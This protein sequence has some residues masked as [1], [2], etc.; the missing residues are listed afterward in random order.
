MRIIFSQHINFSFSLMKT[1]WRSFITYNINF[2]PV[3][4]NSVGSEFCLINLVDWC[5]ISTRLTTNMLFK[6][7]KFITQKFHF[8][9]DQITYFFNEIGWSAIMR[10]SFWHTWYFS[11]FFTTVASDATIFWGSHSVFGFSEY[12]FHCVL[13]IAVFFYCYFF[14][15][16]LINR[17]WIEKPIFLINHRF[18]I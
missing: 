16:N 12:V 9:I 14:L 15:S 4:V 1:Y 7:F 8:L 13:E 17:N 10:L 5:R 2:V 11:W 3:F 6:I 18:C